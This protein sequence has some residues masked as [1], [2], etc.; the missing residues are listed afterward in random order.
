MFPSESQRKRRRNR[1]TWCGACVNMTLPF[2]TRLAEIAVA[3]KGG[4]AGRC[5]LRIFVT[6]MCGWEVEK[7][8]IHITAKPKK[9]TCSYNLR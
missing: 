1:K 9:H 4:G 8:T 6:G 7:K 5:N 2:R 3:A